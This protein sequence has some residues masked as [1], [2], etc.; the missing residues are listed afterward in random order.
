[1]PAA[2]LCGLFLVGFGIFLLSLDRSERDPDTTA[3]AIVALTGG[4]GR[5]ED[6]LDLLAKGFGRRLLITGVN[7][8]TSREG[9]KRLTPRLRELVE[10]CVDLD[11]RARNTVGNATEIG[12]WVRENDFRSLVIVT[13]YYHLPRTLAELGAALPEIRKVPYGVV[14]ARP[15]GE[16][17]TAL[18]RARILL[19]EYTKFVAVSVRLH[20]AG[21]FASGR[22]A[23]AG[24]AS[25]AA[26]SGA[27]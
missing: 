20:V 6:A 22:D 12:R 23:T 24:R 26:A 27:R 1:M 3:D 19:A 18:V 4:A 5:I 25:V 8:R 13:S 16:W 15:D 21:W 2:L 9:I 7:E 11:Y 14:A 10:C 17:S